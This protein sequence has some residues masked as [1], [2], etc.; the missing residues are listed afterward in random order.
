MNEVRQN[1]IDEVKRV[2]NQQISVDT[3]TQYSRDEADDKLGKSWPDIADVYPSPSVSV[4]D[5]HKAKDSLTEKDYRV[6]I[7]EDD[8]GQMCLMV[9]V[10]HDSRK[11]LEK[12]NLN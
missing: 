8:Y 5:L 12:E 11:R 6:S 7:S 9:S 2:C 3:V 4:D 10:T 1:A